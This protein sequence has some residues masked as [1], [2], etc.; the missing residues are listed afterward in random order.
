MNLVLPAVNS[1]QII[2]HLYSQRSTNFSDISDQ[3]T[4]L[5]NTTLIPEDWKSES[6]QLPGFEAVVD[7]PQLNGYWF[8]QFLRHKASPYNFPNSKMHISTSSSII[9]LSECNNASFT[10]STH[11]KRR[12]SKQR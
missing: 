4:N 12:C 8:R 7:V 6:K 1:N 11:S 5:K 3:D 10:C 2:L 9:N